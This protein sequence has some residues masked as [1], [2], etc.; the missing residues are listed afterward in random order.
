MDKEESICQVELGQQRR[1]RLG[2]VDGIRRG[3]IDP[4]GEAKGK[5]RGEGPGVNSAR[6]RR[7]QSPR[8]GLAFS[9][10]NGA[11]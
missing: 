10:D 11:Q 9:T 7:G 1:C 3:R 4:I 5:P 2:P 8:D 6:F